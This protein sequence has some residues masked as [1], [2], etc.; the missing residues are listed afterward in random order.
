MRSADDAK[1]HADPA[2]PLAADDEQVELVGKGRRVGEHQPDQGERAEHP[3]IAAILALAR[4]EIAAGEQRHAG[5]RHGDQRQRDQRRTRQVRP[6]TALA[7]DRKAEVGRGRHNGGDGHSQ[8]DMHG[9]ASVR[10]T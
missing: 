7:N 3:P 4:A 9:R 1:Q 10:R 8:R 2:R 6:E 5:E